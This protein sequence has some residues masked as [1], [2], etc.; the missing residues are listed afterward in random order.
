MCLSIIGILL[1][2]FLIPPAVLMAVIHQHVDYRGNIPLKEVYTASAYGLQETVHTLKTTDG[3]ELWCA[4][5]TAEDP[6]AAVIFLA[7]I[8]KPSVTQFYG[9]AAWLR[10]YG[11]ASLLLEVRAHGASTGSRIGL[12]YTETADVQAAVEYL[13]NCPEYQE[14]P[15]LI[16]GVSMGGAIALN[17]FGQLG[18]IDGC[19]AM[20]PYATFPMEIETQMQRYGVPKPIRNIE[21]WMLDRILEKLYGAEIVR[22]ISPEKQIQ[23]AGK[24]AVLLIACEGDR[25]VPVGN[26]YRLKQK[27]PDAKVWIRASKDHFVVNDNDFD[28]FRQDEE[29]CS[30]VLGWMQGQGFL[31]A[32]QR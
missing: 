32:Q 23:N 13:R 1:T 9:H 18:E 2:V 26:T 25:V 7:G 19:I 24:R 30:Y 3:E 8:T 14:L 16:W 4:E 21:L 10:E 6:K 31:E 28:R 5:I 29:Y 17:A 11:V 20:S 12:G 22:N 27:N 15:M